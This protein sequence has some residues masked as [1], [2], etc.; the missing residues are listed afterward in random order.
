VFAAVCCT[1][2]VVNCV[3]AGV[4]CGKRFNIVPTPIEV[5]S[6]NICSETAVK[7]SRRIREPVTVTSSSTA[8]S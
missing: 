2:A 3:T 4:N 6:S 5:V 7:S 8:S 1:S